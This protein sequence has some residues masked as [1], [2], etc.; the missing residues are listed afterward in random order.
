[1]EFSEML[2]ASVIKAVM[3]GTPVRNPVDLTLGWGRKGVLLC[4]PYKDAG[5]PIL[6]NEVR[7]MRSFVRMAT[8]LPLIFLALVQFAAADTSLDN[9]SVNLSM[10]CPPFACFVEPYGGQPGTPADGSADFSS[11][12]QPWSYSFQTGNPLTWNYN[13]QT[14]DYS[15][16]FGT[17]GTFLM[18]GP[19]G[20]TFTGVITGGNAYGTGQII[21]SGV[22]LSYS[23][24]WSNGV[25]GYGTFTDTYS[26]QFGPQATLNAQVSGSAPEPASLVLLGTGL[27]GALGWKRHTMKL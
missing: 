14:G 20:L 2:G 8:L 19:G 27:L 5:F 7:V 18:N 10:N 21:T 16:T 1:M 3:R 6:V 4:R 24:E 13:D 23:G 26:E 12:G 25:L 11:I 17:G 9:L 15:A 22:Q